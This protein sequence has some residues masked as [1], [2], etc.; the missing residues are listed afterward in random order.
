M[1]NEIKRKHC[2]KCGYDLPITDFFKH[3]NRR[4][5]LQSVCKK[6]SREYSRIKEKRNLE[7]WISFFIEMYGAN[8][9]C[10]ICGTSLK[11]ITN[12]RS[13][14][15]NFDHTYPEAPVPRSP[16]GWIRS[17]KFTEERAGLWKK[18]D[19]GILCGRCNNGLPTLNRK[20]WL[21]RVTIYID[22]HYKYG[23]VK[24]NG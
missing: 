10:E 23:K 21:R 3:N 24:E 20:E 8:P 2:Y 14:I 1:E 4:D 6:C 22:K 5:G 12:N 16:Q 7:K 9:K 19:F 11:W 18:S 17:R 13:E 15:V